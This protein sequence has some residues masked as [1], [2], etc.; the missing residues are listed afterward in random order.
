MDYETALALLLGRR[1]GGT[2][3][4]ADLSVNDPTDPAYVKNRTHWAE[5][6][7]EEI[8][9]LYEIENT[10]AEK[11]SI[12][13]I[14][15]DYYDGGILTVA[16]NG[17]EYKLYAN[18]SYGVECYAM[19]S[20]D[21]PFEIHSYDDGTSALVPYVQ[22]TED[23]ITVAVYKKT[24]TVHPLSPSLGGMP[25]LA[26]DGSDADKTVK[27]TKNGTGY[28]L[29]DVYDVIVKE[30]RASF[31]VSSGGTDCPQLIKAADFET[32][33]AKLD[34][35]ILPVALYGR[36]YYKQD[37]TGEY[38]YDVTYKLV[39]KSQGAYYDAANDY[40]VFDFPNM[41]SSSGLSLPSNRLILRPDG[42]VDYS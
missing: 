11:Y 2:S 9:P 10:G 25:T 31:S 12:P 3:V 40:I 6:S 18:Y 16:Y 22:P 21:A 13:Y 7:V 41:S 17:V 28:E 26:E 20:S 24:E 34:S 15:S 35:G 30:T 36:D 19:M 5:V 8:L 1:S 23:V 37:D 29:V 14:S 38:T 39:Q 32:V 27:V 4:Q 33:L 42:T